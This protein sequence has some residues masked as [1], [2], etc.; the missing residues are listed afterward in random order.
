MTDSFFRQ[1]MGRLQGRFGAKAFDNEFVKLAWGEVQPM[2]EDGF[3]R[4]CNITIGTRPHNRPP[5][6]TE[7]RE[8][9]LAELKAQRQ[10][11]LADVARN[12][13]KRNGKSVLEILKPFV[14]QV[15]NVAEAVEVRTLQIIREKAKNSNYDPMCDRSWMG[16]H[17]WTPKDPA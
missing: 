3:R 4:F 8:A 11:T 15:R 10:T 5:L 9:M 2:T 7:F 17:A 14:G 1:Q 16:Q 6:L 12:F 13:E